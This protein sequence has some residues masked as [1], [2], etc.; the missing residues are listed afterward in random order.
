MTVT[1]RAGTTA[2]TVAAMT[3]TLPIVCLVIAMTYAFGSGLYRSAHTPLWFDEL[4]TVAVASQGSAAGIWHALA[5]AA[6]SNPPT[7]YLLEL[8]AQLLALAPEISYRLAPLAAFVAAGVGLFQ[9]VRTRRGDAA[10]LAAAL[11]LFTTPLFTL[12]AVE[13][14]PY[15]IVVAC[16]AWAMVMW[17]RADRLNRSV[18]LGLLLTAASL[19]HYYAVA[20]LAPFALAE[21]ARWLRSGRFRAGVWVGLAA[22]CLPPVLF[23]PLL[24]SF[25]RE[26]QSTFW[27]HPKLVGAYAELSGISDRWAPPLVLLAILAVLVCGRRRNEQ[28]S[29][30]TLPPIPLEEGLLLA[31]LIALP[32][33]VYFPAAILNAPLAPRY[34][35]S[36]LLGLCAAIAIVASHR[37][38]ALPWLIA[39]T[40]LI[41]AVGQ[42]DYWR[43]GRFPE[44]NSR[45]H[46]DGPVLRRLVA[47][48]HAEGL[49]VV[50]SNGLKYLAA[51]YYAESP[52]HIPIYVTDPA[53]AF[54]LVGTDAMERAVLKLAP[55]LKLRLENRA[56]FL[57]SHSAFLIYSEG[58]LWDWFPDRLVRDGHSVRVLGV[59]RVA[60]STHWL[61]RVDLRVPSAG[62]AP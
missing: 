14:R 12:Y 2:S 18:A 50:A 45:Q 60:T 25:K 51:A 8:A 44:N 23:S 3:A 29:A 19:F 37:A 43:F 28:H 30:T 15:T 20:A 35:L 52:A 61:Y 34:V 4:A 54:E 41:V 13:A 58:E 7:F 38:R 5:S 42:S 53:A 26:Y 55:F 16:V 33:L 56:S 17:Q 24:I 48:A 47:R 1:E 9:F 6:D 27:A 39:G 59:E 31:G 21:A 22:A 32:A 46:F 40:V 10:G 11:L 62:S 49:P 36:M 57:A